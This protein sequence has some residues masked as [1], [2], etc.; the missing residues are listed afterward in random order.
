MKKGRRQTL[1]HSRR[2]SPTSKRTRAASRIPNL[3][4]RKLSAF[5]PLTLRPSPP[6]PSVPLSGAVSLHLPPSLQ[7]SLLL[8]AALCLSQS[9]YVSVENSPSLAIKRLSL[10]LQPSSRDLS[11]TYYRPPTLSLSL[12]LSL[13][14]LHRSSVWYPPSSPSPTASGGPGRLA[15]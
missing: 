4:P 1:R 14:L 15:L 11:A 7:L 8:R 12:Y 5:T 2:E 13:F 3:Q 6:P 9:V 10:H